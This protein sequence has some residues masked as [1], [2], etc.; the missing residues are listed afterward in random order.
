MDHETF[1]HVADIGVRGF[2]R[3]PEE[4]FAGGARA[5]FSVM[6]D[7]ETVEPRTRVQVECSAPDLETLFVEWLNEL[8][9]LSDSEGMAFSDFEVE[10]GKGGTVLKGTARGEPLVPEKHH[11]KTEVKAATYSQMKVE[12]ED[13]RWVAQC[14]VDV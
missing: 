7:L 12:K 6:V 3:S 14:I 13:G 9:F 8:L 11:T 5:M 1:D 4:A 10:I 2:G